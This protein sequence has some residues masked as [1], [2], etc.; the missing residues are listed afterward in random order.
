MVQVFTVLLT[1][2]LLQKY[3]WEQG[4][5][6]EQTGKWYNFFFFLE[7]LLMGT[8]I[9]SI[10]SMLCQYGYTP[11]YSIFSAELCYGY[12]PIWVHSYVQHVFCRISRWKHCMID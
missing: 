9:S 1:N 4:V 8:C 12:G 6:C 11:M 2:Q 3:I 10:N 5:G 7:A